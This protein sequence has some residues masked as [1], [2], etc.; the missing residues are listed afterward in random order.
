[1]IWLRR[2]FMCWWR[3]C[4]GT[5]EYDR[6]GGVVWKCKHCNRVSRG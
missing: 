2:I 4:G 1:M 5:I 6:R 3:G